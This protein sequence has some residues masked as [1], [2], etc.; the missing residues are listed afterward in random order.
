[1]KGKPDQFFHQAGSLMLYV[2]K[3]KN[4]VQISTCIEL[5]SLDTSPLMH[6]FQNSK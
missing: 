3:L 2:L 6:L 5:F 4:E 1:M